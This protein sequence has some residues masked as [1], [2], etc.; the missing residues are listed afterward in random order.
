MR[1]RWEL[2]EE[3]WAVVEPVLRPE[4][5]E[6]NRGRPWQDPR[7]VLHAGASGVGQRSA[8]ARVAGEI[9]SLQTCHR[10]FQQWIRSASWKVLRRGKD[11]KIVAVAAGNSLPLAV[12]VQS[13][14]PAECK[15]V[16]EAFVGQTES[17][18]CRRVR[19]R[20]DRTQPSQAI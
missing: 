17:D 10:R 20:V 1:G 12:S 9:P 14:S 11:T 13:A 7:A 19:Q 6:D 3:Q 16:E 5:R 4:R 15:L 2:T 18:A 8:V